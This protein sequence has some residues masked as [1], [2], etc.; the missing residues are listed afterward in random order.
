MLH[1]QPRPMPMTCPSCCQRWIRHEVCMEEKEEVD[2]STLVRAGRSQAKIISGHPNLLSSFSSSFSPH[3]PQ[4]LST[5]QRSHPTRFK[6]AT[7]PIPYLSSRS[8]RRQSLS[9]ER[10]LRVREPSVLVV[11]Q[12]TRHSNPDRPQRKLPRLQLSTRPTNE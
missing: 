8:C 10:P 11:L 6:S 5:R 2:P 12:P 7:P 1:L 9:C 3:H 4:N